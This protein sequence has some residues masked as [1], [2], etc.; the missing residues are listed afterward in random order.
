MFMSYEMALLSNFKPGYVDLHYNDMHCLQGALKIILN[1]PIV[2]RELE[3]IELINPLC[4]LYSVL[5]RIYSNQPMLN[6]DV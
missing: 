1:H 4:R 2:P 5:H 3:K 6:E